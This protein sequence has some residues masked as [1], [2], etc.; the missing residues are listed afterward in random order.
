MV[1]ML[2]GLALAVV[3]GDIVS[4]FIGVLVGVNLMMCTRAASTCVQ[5]DPAV[6]H[7]LMGVGIGVVAATAAAGLLVAMLAT[8]ALVVSAD[9]RVYGQE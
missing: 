9:Q 1:R 3:L 8:L 7:P 2:R 6:L 4:T 5:C